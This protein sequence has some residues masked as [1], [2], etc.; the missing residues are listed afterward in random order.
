MSKPLPVDELLRIACL[1]A[2][3]DLAGLI[4][5]YANDPDD[6]FCREQAEILSQIQAYRKRRWGRTTLENKM[7]EMEPV[8]ISHILNR[9]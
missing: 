8:K 2:E 5:A 9:Q 6:S 7:D 3:Q 4:D 1:H